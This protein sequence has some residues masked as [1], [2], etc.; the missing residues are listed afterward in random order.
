MALRNG[1][2]RRLAVSDPIQESDK[3]SAAEESKTEAKTVEP[4]KE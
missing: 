2:V 3:A 4:F 1:S